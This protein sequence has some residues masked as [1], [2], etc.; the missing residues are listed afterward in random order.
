MRS[1]WPP[2]QWGLQHF[3]VESR[4]ADDEGEAL[5]LFL[6]LYRSFGTYLQRL[7][8]LYRVNPTPVAHFQPSPANDLCRCRL[9]GNIVSLYQLDVQ[10]VAHTNPGKE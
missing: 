3:G 8:V 4:L 7:T 1:G 6:I 2:E 10:V 5:G 9:Q